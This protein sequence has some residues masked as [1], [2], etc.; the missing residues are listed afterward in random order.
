M[1]QKA[2]Q[3][4][5]GHAPR[6]FQMEALNAVRDGKDVL[7][8]APP[9]AGKSN[10][11]FL[12]TALLG[13]STLVIS[14][15]IA[16]MDDQ[17]ARAKTAG[18][19]AA[20]LHSGIGKWDQWRVAAKWFIGELQ[21]LYISPERL[22]DKN[23]FE[24]FQKKP[25]GLVVIDEAHCISLW[26]SRFRPA[27]KKFG[28]LLNEI[29]KAPVM[30]VT[31]TAKDSVRAEIV[32]SLSMKNI[33]TIEAPFDFKNLSIQVLHVPAYT[34]RL[35]E[36]QNILESE[37]NFP[38]LLYAQT[39]KQC[40]GLRETIGSKGYKTYS[41]HAGMSIEERA[42]VSASFAESK[43]A[44]LV[45]TVAYGMGV[46]KADIRSVIHLGLPLNLEA[47]VQGI[48]RAGRDGKGAKAIMFYGENDLNFLEKLLVKNSE[49]CATGNASIDQSKSLW[50]LFQYAKS[51]RCRVK[52]INR[53]FFNH[54]VLK[55]SKFCGACDNCHKL[56]GIMQAQ[57]GC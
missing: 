21:L 42:K 41:Y 8:I 16:L 29:K 10:C 48:G 55:E 33:I 36:F 1:E 56:E 14:P 43:S 9:G 4:L 50:S 34:K 40:I 51:S 18:L 7:L 3:F 20:A 46:D 6:P 5:K 27:Y 52:E 54:M 32:S 31:A 44:I 45:A 26:G 2:H 39:R 30:A 38:M 28:D 35:A 11:Y 25:P 57:A 49:S 19:S 53:Y 22:L 12:P 23:L 47:Y 15:L 24:V 17:V 13:L 37:E